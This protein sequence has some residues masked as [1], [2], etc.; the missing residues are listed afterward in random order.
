MISCW[1]QTFTYL[2]Y[3]SAL[4]ITAALFAYFGILVFC[5]TNYKKQPAFHSKPVMFNGWNVLGYAG[6]AMYTFEGTAVVLN[7]R[8][9]ARNPKK[10]PRYMKWALFSVIFIFLTLGFTCYLTFKENTKN[11]LT[12]NLQPST[13]FTISLK[14]L[15]VFNVLCSFPVQALCLFELIE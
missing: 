12:L 5:G 11:I 10:Y 1:I 7:L 6:L 8:N 14:F 2:S 13:P 4:G 3:L 15:I 9:E